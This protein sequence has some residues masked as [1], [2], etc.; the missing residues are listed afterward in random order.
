[1]IILALLVAGGFTEWGNWGE[2]TSACGRRTGKR[3]C[4]NPKPQNGG[5][6]CVGVT[7]QTVGCNALGCGTFLYFKGIIVF[8]L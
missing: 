3:T 1:M 7:E 8:V 6:D 5:R 4:T 2:C